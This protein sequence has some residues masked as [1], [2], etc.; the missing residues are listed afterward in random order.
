MEFECK[1]SVR[2]LSGSVVMSSG[3]PVSC[4]I[5]SGRKSDLRTPLLRL[6]SFHHMGTGTLLILNAYCFRT[7]LHVTV[8]VM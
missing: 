4:N 3:R 2:G 8:I 5:L 6:S 7:V 1:V